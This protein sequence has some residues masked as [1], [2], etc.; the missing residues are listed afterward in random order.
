LSSVQKNGVDG[1]VHE[2]VESFVY[3]S[4]SLAIVGLSSLCG[5]A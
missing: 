1:F 4:Y 5:V 2:N 3:C